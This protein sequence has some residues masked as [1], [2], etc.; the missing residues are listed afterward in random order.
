M[1]NFFVN[2]YYTEFQ[3]LVTQPNPTV[4]VEFA[5]IHAD[6]SPRV[7]WPNPKRKPVKPKP[8]APLS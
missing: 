4:P 1:V 6:S 2:I 7:P 3:I 5:F 8:Q